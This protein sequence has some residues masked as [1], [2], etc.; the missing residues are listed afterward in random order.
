M[1]ERRSPFTRTRR[2]HD[3]HFRTSLS[4]L[5]STSSCI[6]MSSDT[7]GSMNIQNDCVWGVCVVCVCVGVWVC[8]VC[9]GVCVCVV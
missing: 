2:T 1:N 6:L 4:E 8:G 3:R 7:I 5:R 9:V